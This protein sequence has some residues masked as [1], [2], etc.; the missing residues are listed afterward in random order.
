MKYW[1]ASPQYI[2]VFWMH[3]MNCS[4]GLLVKFVKL[5]PL[6]VLISSKFS[7]HFLWILSQLYM[8]IMR[9][10]ILSAHTCSVV[11]YFQHQIDLH[12]KLWFPSVVQT[13][14][15]VSLCPSRSSIIFSET[16]TPSIR[17]NHSSVESP[18]S[19]NPGAPRETRRKTVEVAETP[20][21]SRRARCKIVGTRRPRRLGPNPGA[22][23]PG[24]SRGARRKTVG[25]AQTQ[26]ASQA[27]QPTPRG[28]TWP[29]CGL[30]T[31]AAPLV[32][33]PANAPLD[34]QLNS[35]QTSFVGRVQLDSAVVGSARVAIAPCESF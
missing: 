27:R 35:H 26:G 14:Q 3:Q 19:L 16:V 31:P 10:V 28:T 9:L 2:V 33:D 24:A 12:K 18:S 30:R 4:W 29:P 8:H 23:T 34:F 20:G 7:H 1:S 22:T 25:A 15:S 17:Y 5:W 32:I 11:V 21:T 13:R 6:V